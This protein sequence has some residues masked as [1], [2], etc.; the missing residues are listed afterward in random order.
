MLNEQ[1]RVKIIGDIG[2]ICAI[3]IKNVENRAVFLKKILNKKN[4]GVFVSC[5]LQIAI[6]NTGNEFVKNAVI[7]YT[8]IN[9][10]DLEDA[11]ENRGLNDEAD[12]VKRV[13]LE[14]GESKL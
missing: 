3:V 13:M 7:A 14:L 11:L 10:N 1:A 8:K 5:V 12:F 4:K 9:P 2:N 6:K